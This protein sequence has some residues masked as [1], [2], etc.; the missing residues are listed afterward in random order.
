MSAVGRET[1]RRLAA[2]RRFGAG[3]RCLTVTPNTVGASKGDMEADGS[4]N[5]FVHSN[6]PM[7]L[8][9]ACGVSAW[10]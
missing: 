6:M 5:R 10:R 2:Q 1:P 3:Q 9:V 4:V 8:P 7:K